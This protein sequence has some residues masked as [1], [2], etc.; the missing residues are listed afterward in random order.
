M[1]TSELTGA[2]LDYWVAKA[3]GW[4]LSADGQHWDWNQASGQSLKF[5]SIAVESWKPSTD[6]AHG[7]PIME[8]E[9]IGLA[10]KDGHWGAKLGAESWDIADQRFGPTPLIAA[11]RAYVASTYGEEVGDV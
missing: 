2:Q 9:R 3:Q 7:G 5:Y 6:W 10:F 8:R 11:M 4:H 1:K